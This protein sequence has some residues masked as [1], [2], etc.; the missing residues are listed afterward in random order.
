MAR[1]S[2]TASGASTIEVQV[3][4]LD[5]ELHEPEPEPLAAALEGSLDRPEAPVRAK[6]P[7]FP[8]HARGDVQGAP[9]ELPAR[10][11]RNILAQGLPLPASPAPGAAP[12]GEVLL[13]RV[14]VRSVRGGSDTAARPKSP[15]RHARHAPAAPARARRT[16]SL[17]L[18]VELSLESIRT[19][20]VDPAEGV[21]VRSSLVP[22][23]GLPM[24]HG[25]G[26]GDP[27]NVGS[28]AKAAI[29]PVSR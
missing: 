7:H 1:P 21:D 18:A 26:L 4:A 10:D 5:R 17:L 14:H 25:L 8:A 19:L 24:D 23:A 3:V 22:F 28:P 2:A 29:E 9:A 12:E 11:V 13:D 15:L 27:G 6:V 16:W 20:R